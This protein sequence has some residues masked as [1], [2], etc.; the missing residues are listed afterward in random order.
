MKD[1]TRVVRAGLPAAKQG[2]PF[3][4]GPTFA[5]PYHVAGDPASAPYRYARYENPTWTH[6]E[7]ALAELEGGESVVFSSGMA[8]C[9]A[10]LATTLAPGARL[11]LP[12]DGYFAVRQLADE[13]FAAWGVEVVAVATAGTIAD[14]VLRG[15][16][17]VW[18]ET[19]S[20]PGL[21][22]CDIAALA[23]RAHAAGAL[24]AVDNT[25]A[26]PLVQRPLVLG[27]DFSVAADTKALTGHGDLVLGHAAAREATH[28]EAL[29]TW[30]KRTGAI[31]GPMEAWLAHRS[32]ATLD[33]RL[34]RMCANA[35]AIASFLAGRSDVRA[36]RYP[37]LPGDPSHAVASRQMARFGSIV[38]FD[39]ESE[40]RAQRFLSICELVTEATSFGAIHTTAERRARWGGDD[41]SPGF[42]R[43]SAGC[44][45]AGDLVRDLA[46]ALDRS[47]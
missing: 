28:V 38:S 8:A 40:N 32:L 35:L 42:V 23:R 20:N 24:V 19:P 26:T 21:D 14:E 31:L 41:V 17:L 29:R 39:L 1:A 43:L 12:S 27:A 25:T 3:L 9:T 11:V 47:R 13:F 15:A 2:D 4:P 6:F 36:V 7:S 44:E 30:R 33:V 34:E 16:R 22:A 10:V 46:Q 18:I 37:G 45:D 5:A